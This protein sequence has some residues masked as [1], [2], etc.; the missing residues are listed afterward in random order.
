MVG[1]SDTVRPVHYAEDDAAA[2]FLALNQGGLHD[3]PVPAPPFPPA[4]VAPAAAA[5]AAVVCLRDTRAPDPACR[6]FNGG[7][8]A[9]PWRAP[10]T[11]AAAPGKSTAA[12][13]D[14][15]RATGT[16]TCAN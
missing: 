2:D 11:A 14:A 9:A 8:G 4:A 5:P 15:S 13:P 6:G 1:D 7:G 10:S 16:C 12:R 3:F